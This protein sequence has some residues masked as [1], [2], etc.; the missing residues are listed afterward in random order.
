M[1]LKVA[2]IKTD[3]SRADSRNGAHLR[4]R[5]SGRLPEQ[6]RQ[7]TLAGQAIAKTVITNTGDDGKICIF[8]ETATDLV[9]D[10]N[11][12]HPGVV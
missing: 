8:T 3:T 4:V 11:G 1:V 9:L 10:A 7:T 2:R 5:G 12:Y 6:G